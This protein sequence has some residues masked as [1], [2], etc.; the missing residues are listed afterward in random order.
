LS[1]KDIFRDFTFNTRVIY[2]NQ[3]AVA[4]RAPLQEGRDMPAFTPNNGED[5]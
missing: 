4:D 1:L 2:T 5:K 3:F